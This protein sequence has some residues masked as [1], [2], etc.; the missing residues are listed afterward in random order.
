MVIPNDTICAALDYGGGVC[1]GPQTFVIYS[2]APLPESFQLLK[3]N[4]ALYVQLT[5]SASLICET[6]PVHVD[7]KPPAVAQLAAL[8][9]PP[10]RMVNTI[11]HVPWFLFPAATLEKHCVIGNGSAVKSLLVILQRPWCVLEVCCCDIETVAAM[12]EF[13]QL[14]AQ[15]DPNNY[16]TAVRLLSHEHRM[17]TSPLTADI[18]RSG[19]P[20]ASSR[21]SVKALRDI[22]AA[23]TLTYSYNRFW[24]TLICSC[25]VH[26]DVPFSEVVRRICD[27]LRD[28]PE[29][30]DSRL[31]W[32][33]LYKVLLRKIGDW[34]T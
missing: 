4:I 23:T 6:L 7:L 14:A 22:Y 17:R 31:Y 18:S 5:T 34:V 33:C 13:A 19:D 20:Y 11:Y 21:C 10:A 2:C 27:G 29:A 15:V 25:A 3:K 30:T 16:D 9:V 12:R 24:L 8:P 32:I 28:R 1:F 26:L